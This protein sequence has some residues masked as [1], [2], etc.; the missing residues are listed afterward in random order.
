MYDH[1]K[2][3]PDE[4]IGDPFAAVVIP[5]VFLNGKV[6]NKKC[7]QL[8]ECFKVYWIELNNYV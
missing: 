7:S 2:Q 5:P 6:M 1:L 3:L 8:D 4:V